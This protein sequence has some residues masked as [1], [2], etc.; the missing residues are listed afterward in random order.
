MI[1]CTVAL[2]IAFAS[3]GGAMPA[4]TWPG[5]GPETRERFASQGLDVIYNTPEEFAKLLVSDIGRWA[6]VV[7]RAGVQAE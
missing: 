6:K 3:C 5:R 7:E 2:L 4:K 1:R